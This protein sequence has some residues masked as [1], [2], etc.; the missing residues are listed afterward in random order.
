MFGDKVD[1][2]VFKL[3]KYDFKEC[4]DYLGIFFKLL[5]NFKESNLVYEIL[6]K[7]I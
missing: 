1:I 2:V 5:R 4:W 7:V 6:R 3:F